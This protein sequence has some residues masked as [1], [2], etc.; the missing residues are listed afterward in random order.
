MRRLTYA[1]AFALLWVS[2]GAQATAPT[3]R[4][5]AR[6]TSEV[7]RVLAESALWN[8]K[9]PDERLKEARA[10]NTLAQDAERVFG[11]SPFGEFGKCLNMAQLHRDFVQALNELTRQAEV[12]TGPQDTQKALFPL[13]T[14][15]QLG[16]TYRTCSDR[17]SELEAKR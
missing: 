6:F 10:A 7:R 13:R 14:A 5:A 2:A 3:A 4:D 1:L 9:K 17:V 8:K 12:G 15:F 16:E 11:D